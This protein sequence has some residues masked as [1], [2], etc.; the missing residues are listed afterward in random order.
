[1]SALTASA[2]HRIKDVFH[3]KVFSQRQNSNH[4]GTAEQAE[5]CLFIGSVYSDDLPSSAL[6]TQDKEDKEIAGI[7]E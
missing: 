2:L 3:K 4:T 7:K 5:D 1:M 6:D